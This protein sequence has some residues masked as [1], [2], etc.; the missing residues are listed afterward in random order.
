MRGAQEDGRGA[1][2]GAKNR[3][4][5]SAGKAGKA[6]EAVWRAAKTVVG[7]TVTGQA[8]K[9]KVKAHKVTLHQPQRRGAD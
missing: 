3:D 8:D 5:E 1:A 4:W 7:Y 6:G 2:T 9:E